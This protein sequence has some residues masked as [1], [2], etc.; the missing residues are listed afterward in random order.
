MSTS[1][2]R[3]VIIGVDTYQDT[4]IRN[5]TGARNDA[6]E[7]HDRLT[8]SG[9]FKVEE[10]HLLLNENAS[11][12]KIRRAISDLLWKTDESELSLLYFSGHGL[13]DGYGNGFIAPYDID[14]NCPLVCGIR[15]Q[16]LRELMLS[17]RN[18]KTVLLI[19]DCCYSG[20]ASDGEKTVADTPTATVEQCLAALDEAQHRGTGR[21]I[22]TSS[23]SDER[24]REMAKCQHRLGSQ[25]PHPH[26]AFT[27]QILEGLDGRAS[28]NGSEITIGSLVRC[29]DESFAGSIEH[30]PKL[31][32][33]AISSLDNI[34]LCRASRQAELELQVRQ[35][36]EL[37]TDE[38]DMF[39]LFRAI[40][41]LEVILAD[42]PGLVEAAEV[43]DLI[44]SRLAMQ[45]AD[46]VQVLTDGVLELSDGCKTTFVR[47]QT[48][49]CREN[50]DFAAITVEETRLRN[51]ILSLLQVARGQTHLKVLQS[52]LAAYESRATNKLSPSPD[53]TTSIR[54]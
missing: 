42:S 45:R 46:A 22:L 27:Y 8:K 26:G 34:L 24:S 31:Y 53:G 47:L 12:A 33:S 10:R 54:S 2:R 17:A 5:L 30:Q 48:A 9:D 11:A 13:T 50:F 1:P 52:Q 43:R 3:A 49:V 35:V 39:N 15:M 20:I 21:L 37:L 41:N 7:M 44:D 18:K 38:E 40:K 25:P 14:K 19:L 4:G 51:L 29:M 32:G 28:T 6:E 36:R 23:G 16:E